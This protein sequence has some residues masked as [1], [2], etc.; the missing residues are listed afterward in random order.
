MATSAEM[1]ALVAQATANEDAESSAVTLLNALAAQLTTVAGNKQATL[2]LAT[3][4]KTS[5]DAL[6]AAVV[7]NTPAA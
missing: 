5:S 4:L 1:D 6:G 2:D 3:A 7:A